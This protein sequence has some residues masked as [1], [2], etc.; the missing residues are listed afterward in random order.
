M[1]G[2]EFELLAEGP[3]KRNT[4][5]W[6]GRTDNFKQVMFDAPDG[7]KPGDFISVRIVRATSMS[8]YGETI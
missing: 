3:S 6:M 7:L 1:I 5:R 2:R 8:L 4:A